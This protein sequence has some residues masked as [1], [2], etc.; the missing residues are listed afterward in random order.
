MLV[1]AI[2]PSL[3]VNGKPVAG[4]L[5]NPTLELYQKGNPLPIARNDDWKTDQQSDIA[6]TGIPPTNDRESAIVMTLA[7]GAYTAVVRGK[8]NT[9]GI[10]LAEAF[11][12]S[13]DA[14]SVVANLST[15]GYVI[16]P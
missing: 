4:R 10:A 11:D 7:P 3:Q 8:N 12:V 14:S 6:A 13:G 15:R 5:D 2:G 1:R 9:T 16:T